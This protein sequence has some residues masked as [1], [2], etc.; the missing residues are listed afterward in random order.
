M[1]ALK[2]ALKQVAKLEYSVV[3]SDSA[4]RNILMVDRQCGAGLFSNATTLLWDL[5]EC[6]KSELDVHAISAGIGLEFYKNQIGDDPIAEL[7]EPSTTSLLSLPIPEKPDHH[8]IYSE[9]D[10]AQLR[11]YV[12]AFFSPSRAVKNLI[13]EIVNEYLMAPGSYSCLCYRG[14]D[15]YTELRL[16]SPQKFSLACNA[17]MLQNNFNSSP[18]LIQTDDM[19]AYEQICAS[20]NIEHFRITQMPMTREKMA[21]HLHNMRNRKEFSKLLLAVNLLISKSK[22]LVTHTGNMALWQFLYRGNSVNT[23]QF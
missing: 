21:I 5:I 18:L 3:C 2:M 7:F 15:K 10:F 23:I 6:R 8:C 12:K 20:L 16:E 4:G 1:L 17:L 11:P 14:T 22:I 9:L 19:S 13:S